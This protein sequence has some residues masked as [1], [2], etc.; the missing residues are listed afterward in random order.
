MKNILVLLC[1]AAFLSGCEKYLD[2]T[3]ESNGLTE[4]DVFTDELK[5]RQFLDG[6]YLDLNDYLTGD[7]QSFLGAVCDEGYAQ[8]EW[9]TLPVVQG[10]NWL[11]AYTTAGAYQFG[12]VWD[13]SWHGIRIADICIQNISQLEG[14]ATGE[15]IDQLKGQA[16][17]LRAWFYFDLLRRQGGMPYLTEPLQATDNFNIPRLSYTET[18]ERIAADCDTANDLLPIRWG[19]TDYGRPTRGAALALKATALLFSASPT[20]NPANDMDLW[21]KAAAASWTFINFSRSN[22]VYRLIGSG[23]ANDEVQY[24]TPDGVKEFSYAGSGRDSVF[25]YNFSNDEII[26]ED[27]Q[28]INNSPYATFG[29]ADLVPHSRLTGYSPSQN[30]VDKFE[31][32]NGL[33]I[34]DDPSFK[35]DDPYVNRDPRFYQSILFNQRQWTSDPGKFLELF[36]GGAERTGKQYFSYTGYLSNKYWPSYVS[37]IT[38]ANPPLTHTIYLRYA[39]LLLQYAEAANEI[40]GPGYAVEGADM[41]AVDA[42]NMVRARVKMPLVNSIYLTDKN[43][44][45]ERIRNERAVELY[46]ENKRFF[47][48]KRWHLSSEK[49]YKDIYAMD[50]VEDATQPTGYRFQRNPT[51]VI[52]LVFEPKQYRFPIPLPDGSM[53]DLFQQNPGW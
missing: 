30:I 31:T 9:E 4:P 40:G 52:S 32:L 13:N 35:E 22:Q 28:A 34:N 18:A 50:I 8:S 49:A 25:M 53:F 42:V 1:I 16:Y 3:P 23:N 6:M 19:P 17:F 24:A 45:R 37:N 5:F 26:W 46:L 27:F 36:N 7:D 41:S 20:N 48:L 2:K 51:P 44:F 29:P 43:T 15:V 33:S 14:H 11:S 12:L 10:G 47:D 39:D 21:K 38:N